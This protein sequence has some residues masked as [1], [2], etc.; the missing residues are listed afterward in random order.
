MRTIWKGAISFGLVTIPVG[1]ASATES[2][3][4]SFR[5]VHR[6]D[7]ARVRQERICSAENRPVAWE[8]VGR[9][10]ELPD[11]R[12]LVLDDAELDDLPLPSA[13]LIEVN[14]FLPIL[15]IDPIFFDRSYYV[16]PQQAGRR[17]YLLLRDTLA[18][19]Q[20]AAV[21]KVAIRSRE[22]LALL[23]PYGDVLSLI[24]LLWP[25]E[26][27]RPD[28]RFIVN[29]LPAVREQEYVMAEQLVESLSTDGLDPTA[30]RDTYR[31]ALENLINAKLTGTR[32]TAP[33]PRAP[34]EPVD[35]EIALR[36]SLTQARQAP[37]QRS[38]RR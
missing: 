21:A 33:A 5:Q 28:F 4:I 35:L 11:G 37:S 12:I 17:A 34:A 7:G 20:K 29:E 6:S 36:E 31:E 3:R 1:L 26:V 19:T 9:G 23:R 8:E 27:R 25:D 22:R 30:Y 18:K 32:A 14:E 10:Y 24:T 2:K 15:A 13:H 16:H 38:A